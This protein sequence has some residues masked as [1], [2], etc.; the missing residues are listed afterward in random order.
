M[1]YPEPF[2]NKFYKSFYSSLKFIFGGGFTMT[3]F[4]ESSSTLFFF[5]FPY[6]NEKLIVLA[7]LL[8]RQSETI[9]RPLYCS[10][11]NALLV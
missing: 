2:K 1:L 9:I 11:R 8:F 3:Q 10:V 7:F 4:T 5:F 6:Q